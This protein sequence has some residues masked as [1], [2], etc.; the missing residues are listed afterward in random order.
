MT[1]D[2]FYAGLADLITAKT[3]LLAIWSNQQARNPNSGRPAPEGASAKDLRK[4]VLLAPGVQRTHAIHKLPDPKDLMKVKTIDMIPIEVRF[5]VSGIECRADELRPVWSAFIRD[6]RKTSLS[7]DWS[8]LY[9]GDIMFSPIYEKGAWKDR[10]IFDCR[11]LIYDEFKD[12]ATV[13]I[14]S[15]SGSYEIFE[16]TGRQVALAGSFDTRGV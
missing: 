2:E 9:V 10:Y 7:K 8:I 15:V 4:Y 14:E 1:T 11:A 6:D 16:P 5:T 12:D 13:P 3:K